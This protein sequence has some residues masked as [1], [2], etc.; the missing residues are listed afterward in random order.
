MLS[1]SDTH[2]CQFGNIVMHIAKI[3]KSS[4][5]FLLVSR[6]NES[7]SFMVTISHLDFN[8]AF[9]KYSSFESCNTCFPNVN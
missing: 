7:N 9:S 2:R 8:K 6:F 1:R 3:T 5:F 4:S